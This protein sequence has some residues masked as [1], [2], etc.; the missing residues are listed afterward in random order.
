MVSS[1][2]LPNSISRA[3][4]PPLIMVSFDRFIPKVEKLMSRPAR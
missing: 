1:R 2:V 3:M 4:M